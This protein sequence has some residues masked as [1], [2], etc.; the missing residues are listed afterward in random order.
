VYVFEIKLSGTAEEALEQAE[1]RG[2]ATPYGADARKE[3][4]QVGVEFDQGQRNISRWLVNDN[5]YC[6]LSGFAVQ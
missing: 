5:S 4:V 1:A 2:Y 3:V 6:L